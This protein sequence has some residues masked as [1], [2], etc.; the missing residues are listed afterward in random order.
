MIFL[1]LFSIASAVLFTPAACAELLEP[2]QF[3]HVSVQQ[4]L[5]QITITDILEDNIGFMW[6]STQNGI[7]RYDGYTFVQYQQDREMD[8]SG[9]IGNY[10]NKLALDKVTGDIWTASTAGLSRFEHSSERF[11]HYPLIDSDKVQHTYVITVVYDRN[12]QLW[13]GTNFGLFKYQASSD[14]FAYVDLGMNVSFRV[15]DIEQDANGYIWLATS[16][17]LYALSEQGTL[18]GIPMLSGIDVTDIKLL[19]EGQIWFATSGAGIYAKDDGAPGF[20]SLIKLEMLSTQLQEGSVSSINQLKNGNIWISTLDGLDIVD[21]SAENEIIHLE[22]KSKVES[23]LSDRH[24]TRTVESRSGIIWQ[25]T[26]NAGVSIFDP[27]ILQFKTLNAGSL[28]AT[29]GIDNDAQ[30]NIWFSTPEGIWQRKIDGTIE[31]PW[32]YSQ[33]DLQSSFVQ[34]NK[35]VALMR[36]K[37]SNKLWIGTRT[38]VSVLDIDE[39]YI[40]PLEVLKG[41][42]IYSLAEDED[43]DIWLGG[44]NEGVYLLDS[45]S[46]EIKKQWISG[47]VL[48][49]LPDADNKVWAGSLNGLIRVDKSSDVVESF[50]SDKRP[51]NQRSPRVVTSISKA[52]KG[53]FWLG[54]QGD[55]LYH[56]AV[57]PVSKKVLFDKIAPNSRL[58]ALSIGG[59]EEQDNGNLWISTTEGI[60]RLHP[61]QENIEYFSKKNGA[62]SEG[63]F[64]NMNLTNVDGRMFFGSPSGITNFMPED[65]APSGWKPEII[66]TKLSILNSPIFPLD[67]IN[68]STPIKEPIP[69]AKQITLG[70]QDIV[71]SLEFSALDFSAPAQNQYAYK[72]EGFDA[73]WNTASA[74]N[75]TATYTNLD[76]GN[77]KL[78]VK[79]TNKDGV[80]SD[81]IGRIDI[82]VVPPWWLTNWAVALWVLIFI[83]LLVSF[84]RWRVVSLKKR[85]VELALLVERRTAELE[86]AN[87]RLLRI[88]SIDDLTGLRNRR[89]FRLNALKEASRVNRGGKPFSILMIDIDYFKQVNDLNGHACGDKVLVETSML[90]QNLIRQ[91]DML[92]RWGGEEFI[93]LIVETDLEEGL[94]IAE[95]LRLM[96][97]ENVIKYDD[98]EVRV[99]VSVGVSQIGPNDSLDECINRADENLYIA[100][101]N[102]RNTVV[103][104]SS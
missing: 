42:Y 57:D 10:N 2:T 99:S 77:Y 7:N 67:E 93:L 17:G 39:Q 21:L 78:M 24:M 32:T 92:A 85:A 52:S 95:K 30:G 51:R 34:E 43:G 76:P 69:I 28:D 36:S 9:P 80:W 25:G 96:I 29:R 54:A 74:K 58:A 48:Q 88:S 44:F 35:I 27:N 4:G 82:T 104:E 100:K 13:V 91:Q 72:L 53:G 49:I 31:G 3:R 37:F 90:M 61:Q 59:V 5:S 55:G 16:R 79:G 89:D 14:S 87:E 71:F 101:K 98:I 40:R 94:Q 70:P 84:Y 26:W 18:T 46:F 1:L 6:F 62:K 73:D 19:E 47:G 8:G 23:I 22:Y 86:S 50:R 63:Y 66:F 83:S 33:E 12:G 65:I 81:K 56:M 102:G 38:G 75:R 64:I 60:T 97:S 15:T 68:G 11:I 20:E 103:T 41:S 45:E